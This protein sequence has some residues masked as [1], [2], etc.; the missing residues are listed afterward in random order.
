MPV[1]DDLKGSGGLADN[2]HNVMSVWSNKEKK[3]LQHKIENGYKPDAE[4]LELL[5]KPDVTI[6]IKK[7]R[8][9]PFEGRIGLWRTQAR[10]FHRKGA[11][12]KT[13]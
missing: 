2:A 13:L 4:E 3:E 1:V 6:D 9:F 12:V 5:E 10:A 7:Q 11:R 8:K